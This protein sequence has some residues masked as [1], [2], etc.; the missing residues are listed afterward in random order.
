M[1]PESKLIVG[2]HGESKTNG[3]TTTANFDTL[4]FDH[5]IVSVVTGTANVVSN[6]P[7]VLKISESDDTVVTNFADIT[8]LVG[9]GSGGWTIPN[10]N[11]S[12]DNAVL[13]NVGLIGR[14]RYLK[15]T[16][17]PTTTQLI[18]ATAHLTRGDEAPST[19][20]EQSTGVLAVVH[21]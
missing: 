2:V 13:F 4:G 5:A 21:A 7:S 11:T 20:N 1:K 8:A 6:N 15:V 17:S 9:D 14:K 3:A 18:T 12:V 16:V 10:A 19:T